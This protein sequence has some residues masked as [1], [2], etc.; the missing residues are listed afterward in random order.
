MTRVTRVLCPD[1]TEGNS[2]LA[3]RGACRPRP[4]GAEITVGPH[5]CTQTARGGVPG[6]FQ[7]R[8]V[9][10]PSRS[11]SGARRPE[12][13]PEGEAYS[14]APRHLPSV[15]HK[16]RGGARACEQQKFGL[17][18]VRVWERCPCVHTSHMQMCFESLRVWS[19]FRRGVVLEREASRKC[20][21]VRAQWL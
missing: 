14:T 16:G 9:A 13:V 5:H 7:C 4:V 12:A 20:R 6:L 15:K 2:A 10:F 17:S 11:A 3:R 18:L 1:P 19:V 21:C 8:A